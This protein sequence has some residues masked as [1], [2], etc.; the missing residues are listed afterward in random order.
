MVLKGI[1]SRFPGAARKIGLHGH[2]SRAE[3]HMA[4]GDA[5]RDRGD[6]KCAVTAYAQAVSLDTT[7]PGL[8]VQ[9]GH[10]LKETGALNAAELRY[11][12]AILLEPG[13]ADTYVQ[14][15]HALKLQ[16]DLAGALFAYRHASEL[17]P[18]FEAAHRE[19]SALGRA[20]YIS[21][22]SANLTFPP[23]GDTLSMPAIHT[24]HSRPAT[25]LD[26]VRAQ[27]AKAFGMPN[28]GRPTR[29]TI[30]EIF[31]RPQ[32]ADALMS[33]L[34][35]L[36]RRY[37]QANATHEFLDIVRFIARSLLDPHISRRFVPTLANLDESF[38]TAVQAGD[39]ARDMRNWGDAEFQ[40]WRALSLY[41]K[42][43]GYRVQYAHV[44]KEA[45][46]YLDAEVHY[47]H[48]FSQGEID[49]DTVSFI[50]YSQSKRDGSWADSA[51]QYVLEYWSA[52]RQFDPLGAPLGKESVELIFRVF[53]RRMP[54]M[55]EA[56]ENMAQYGSVG[57]IIKHLTISTEFATANRDLLS[58]IASKGKSILT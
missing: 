31:G 52:P 46:K 47:R 18:H 29:T 37:A 33:A 56:A 10:A 25:A 55:I 16:G 24:A 53:Y 57:D 26:P 6:W 2:S 38:T 50:Q 14:L 30:H 23:A 9:Y 27:L 4:E 58:L 1:I 39:K 48:A 36:K 21:A 11:R 54:Q 32:S 5:A 28:L 3:R 8:L 19:I 51:H 15:G 49:S 35:D 20:G 7:N 12:E 43:M 42:H 22:T 17:D 13:N 45:G 41:P 44:L 34:P 40:Y